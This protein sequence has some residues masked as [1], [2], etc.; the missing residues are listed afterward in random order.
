MKSGETIASGKKSTTAPWLEWLAS[1]LGLLIAVAVFSVL[2]WNAIKE[3]GSPPAVLVHIEGVTPNEG[4]F[5]IEFHARNPT[6]STA[7]QVEVEGVLKQGH[8]LVETSRTT[9]DFVPAN[10]VRRAGLF[11]AHD[12]RNF[13]VRLRALGYSEP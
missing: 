2:L 6:D 7:A 4:G 5:T 13:E 12:P 8:E 11:F 9:L 3:S 10:S 1:G